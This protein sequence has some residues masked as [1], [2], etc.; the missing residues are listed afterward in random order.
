MTIKMI[1]LLL[2]LLL[3]TG[4]SMA[5]EPNTRLHTATFAS[6]CFWCLEPPF[7][8][9]A[10]LVSTTPG[11]IWGHVDDP[12]YREVSAGGTGHAEIVEVLY[13]P[14]VVGCGELLD[15]F[16]RNIYPVTPN[17][18]FCDSGSQYRSGLFYHDE[19]QERLARE[20]R[21][22]LERSERF[23]EPIATEIVAATRFYKTKRRSHAKTTT[24]RTRFGTNFIAI[25][26][27]ERRD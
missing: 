11:Y 5:Q 14:S 20:S 9:L 6:G 19:E 13:D 25:G 18:Q 8:E 21:E 16:W 1:R 26:A 17:R 22:A 15:V 12:T 7:N 2:A 23:G 27:A 10:G 3:A 4:V 24:S